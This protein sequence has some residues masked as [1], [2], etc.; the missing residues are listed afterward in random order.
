M[1]P[2][3]VKRGYSEVWRVVLRMAGL[4]AASQTSRAKRSQA[5]ATLM[6]LAGNSSAPFG[7]SD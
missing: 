4:K 5:A 1:P 3:H 7:W 6:A 2:E